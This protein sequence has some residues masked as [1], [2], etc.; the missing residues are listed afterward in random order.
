M[1]GKDRSAPPLWPAPAL[2]VGLAAVAFVLAWRYGWPWEAF[3]VAA[4]LAL[5]ALAVE[6]W[7]PGEGCPWWVYPVYLVS[8]VALIILIFFWLYLSGG[9]EL[10]EAVQ[11]GSA[12]VIAFF[13]ITLWRSTQAQAEATR[14]MWKLQGELVRTELN[15]LLALEGSFSLSLY[16]W[17]AD[18]VHLGIYLRKAV[19]FG[20]TGLFLEKIEWEFAEQSF[21]VELD[22]PLF[23]EKEVL[24]KDPPLFL[25]VRGARA[26]Q[27]AEKLL[28]SKGNTS[29][30]RGGE[31]LG[32]LRVHIVKASG[33][34]DSFTFHLRVPQE[35]GLEANVRISLSFRALSYKE[36]V[37]WLGW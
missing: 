4:G 27:L 7:R 13:T 31:D 33:E 23:P 28:H 24:F 36:E 22:R 19:N 9:M 12:V 34:K 15:P 20:R 14:A 1:A 26:K 17:D 32:A 11:A 8:F 10:A 37:V 5:V 18:G 3:L 2:L 25:G 35:K 16:E 29:F 30:L 6:L 21:L